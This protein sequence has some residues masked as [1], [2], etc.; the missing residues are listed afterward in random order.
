MSVPEFDALV[1]LFLEGCASPEQAEVGETTA[2]PLSE[3]V[4]P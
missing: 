1:G 4:E 2:D 3:S